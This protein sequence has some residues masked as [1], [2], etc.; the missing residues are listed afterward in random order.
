M[1]GGFYARVPEA[2][3]R[4]GGMSSPISV[5]ELYNRVCNFVLEPNGLQTG[6]LTETQVLDFLAGAVTEFLANSVIVSLPFAQ[7][8]QFGTAW[9][10]VPEQ[11]V[12][13]LTVFANEKILSPET[14]DGLDGMLRFWRK[15]P[16]DTPRYW[17]EDR[18]PSKVVEITPSPNYEGQFF[19]VTGGSPY[20]GT[21][22][23]AATFNAYT[24]FYGTIS[25]FT[26][27]V[28]LGTT[29]PFYGTISQ[30]TPSAGN[31][32][33]IGAAKLPELSFTLADYIPFVP[34]IWRDYLFY[35]VLR[36]IY[37]DISETRD[38]AR[39]QYCEQRWQEGLALSR[40]VGDEALSE[41]WA[42]MPEGGMR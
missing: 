24:P 2:I 31:I 33:M 7:L 1:A 15:A 39:A 17:H 16:P 18:L 29:A 8:A 11:L 32:M 37:R 9:Y 6:V 21:L 34:P 35:G 14:A 36:R 19:G 26:G 28:W 10:Q 23:A 20:Y 38:T 22:S 42:P 41:Q 40:I 12:E 5:L 3:A 30:I 13:I 27:P 4:G 25:G